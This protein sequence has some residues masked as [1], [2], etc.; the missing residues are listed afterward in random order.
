MKILVLNAG[1][2]SQ[3]SALYE[4]GER[5][6]R[7]APQALWDADIE[8]GGGAEK[9]TLT[10]TTASG[11][12]LERDVETTNREAMLA[13]MFETL[14]SGETK[15]LA[16]RT[17]IDVV[18]HRVVHGGAEFTEAVRVT[19]DVQAAIG[20]LA[21]FAPL[22][23][24]LNLEGIEAVERTLGDV[25]Q[26][27]VFDTAF[28][29][30]MPLVAKVYSGP[31]A[32]YEQGIRRYGFQGMSHQ[33]CAG[34]AA[35]L[36]ERDP[37]S[38]RI[39]T[40]HLGSGCSLA[41]IQNGRSIDTTMG[42]TPLDGVMMGTRSGSLDPGILTYLLREKG[43]TAESLDQTLN[44]ES[45]LLGISG[46]AGDLREVM[47]ARDA[48]NERAR[49]AYD[50]FVYRIRLYLSAMLTALGGADAIVFTAGIGEHVSAV[51]SDVCDAFGYVGVRLDEARN[52]APKGD[53]DVAAPE[54]SV[55]VL[56]IHTQE[57]WMIAR[58]A[59]KV[60]QAGR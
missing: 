51:R 39:V 29:A 50:L 53:M 47:R 10:V 37:A 59:W 57:D 8:W 45:G 36:L 19:A 28:H 23:N 12:S 58:E 21:E 22:H 34:R 52:A 46:I 32:W 3:K 33:Y 56:V 16:D 41:A 38:L 44:H 49:L 54:S 7:D 11:A 18:G 40:C 4:I 5:L 1:S 42:F 26:V 2:T 25:P 9:S 13:A 17:E 14:W 48:G 30:Q 55:R 27:A 24:P 35:E 60:T 6:P 15:V 31:Y 43:A 20:R